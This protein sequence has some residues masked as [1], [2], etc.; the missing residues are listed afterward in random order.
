MGKSLIG[1]AL[2]SPI[3]WG[4]PELAR[5]LSAG[6]LQNLKREGVEFGHYT[7]SAFIPDRVVE[8]CIGTVR[9]EETSASIEVHD[10]IPDLPQ[11][12]A[13]LGLNQAV[14]PPAIIIERLQNAFA[15][16]ESVAA[17]AQSVAA[18]VRVLHPLSVAS[19]DSS[20]SYSDPMIP[21]SVFIGV[22]ATPTN[23]VAHC[24]AEQ[25]LRQAMYI[26]LSLIDKTVP[27]LS[28]LRAQ[29]EPS[30]RRTGTYTDDV[31]HRLYSLR[32][33]QHFMAICVGGT[34]TPEE[35][36]YCETRVD[37]IDNEIAEIGD[38]LACPGLTDEGAVLAS[39]LLFARN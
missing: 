7:T 34:L 17:A 5:S 19:A 1:A 3:P 2:R 39:S 18:L 35:R 9:L 20:F 14:L 29:L 15:F 31:L 32:A 8:R 38:V 11:R 4:E 25:V 10:F 36:E 21:F 12:Y 33:V 16:L 23:N 27:L 24:I 30:S 26:Q 37:S 22:P 28:P 6:K 13:E